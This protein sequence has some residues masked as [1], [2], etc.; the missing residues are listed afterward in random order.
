MKKS[1]GFALTAVLLMTAAHASA[2]Q[3]Y[4]PADNSL[5]SELCA[6]AGNQGTAAAKNYA[7]QKGVSFDWLAANTSCNGI[8]MAELARNIPP[9]TSGRAAITFITTVDD[10]NTLLCIQALSLKQ[11]AALKRHPYQNLACNGKPVAD[12]WREVYKARH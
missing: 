8:P 5:A 4:E 1:I 2:K 3:V 11:D 12:F 9:S 6:V 10:E 7:K